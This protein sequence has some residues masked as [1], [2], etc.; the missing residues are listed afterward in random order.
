[1]LPNGDSSVSYGGKD[2]RNTTGAFT[3][4]PIVHL[5]D[6]KPVER[7]T[8][9][10]EREGSCLSRLLY[11]SSEGSRDPRRICEAFWPHAHTIRV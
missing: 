11:S 1:M 4:A 2:Y 9:I 7:L 10:A 3:F 8:Y 6:K 5:S